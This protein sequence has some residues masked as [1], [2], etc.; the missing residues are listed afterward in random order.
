MKKIFTLLLAVALFLPQGCH[1]KKAD[2]IDGYSEIMAIHDT[3]MPKMGE[4][5]RTKRKLQKLAA[6][7]TDSLQLAQIN[8]SIGELEESD[9]LMQDWMHN[10]AE[11]SKGI[12]KK[13]P[14]YQQFLKEQKKSIIN[15]SDRIY[16]AMQHANNTLATFEE[17]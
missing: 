7:I 2:K 5:H 10:W 6:H 3:V 1:S 12:D 15:V 8:Y 9:D 4:V 11:K 16:H 13:T 14:E 17:K